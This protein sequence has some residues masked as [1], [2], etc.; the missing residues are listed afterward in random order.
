MD[1]TS[2]HCVSAPTSA[3]QKVPFVVLHPC[4][5]YCLRISILRRE[6]CLSRISRYVH[7]SAQPQRFSRPRIDKMFTQV[8]AGG[9]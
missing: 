5:E 8:G 2:E 1:S 9:R 3:G 4:E 7:F 6:F